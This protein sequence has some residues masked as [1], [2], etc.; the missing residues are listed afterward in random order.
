MAE[1]PPFL[2]LC[3][4][5]RSRLGFILAATLIGVALAGIGAS[6]VAPKYTAKAQVLVDT[7]VARGEGDAAATAS[8]E[9]EEAAMQTEVVE[10]T[11]RDLLRRTVD[12]FA[13]SPPAK[14]VP[15]E[16]AEAAPVAYRPKDALP[17][18]VIAVIDEGR[19][20][21]GRLFG[22]DAVGNV[23]GANESGLTFDELER[24]LFVYQERTS[25]VIAVTFTA[26]SPIKAAAVANRIVELY[27]ADHGARRREEAN[28]TLDWLGMREPELAA[29]L[30]RAK[31]AVADY[32][33]ANAAILAN[34][35]EIF[36][37]LAIDLSHQ[38][39][40]AE[41]DVSTRR[42]RAAY[43]R[44]LKRRGDADAALG[45]LN[46]PLVAELSQQELALL[47]TQAELAASLGENHPKMLQIRSQL[48]EIRQRIGQEL[49]LALTAL[50]RE[51]QLSADQLGA[52]RDRLRIAKEEA[53]RARRAELGLHEL[54]L[55]ADSKRQTFDDVVK[56][57]KELRDQQGLIRA[58]AQILTTAMP[59]IKP[60]SPAP[61]L[62]LVPAAVIFSICSGLWVVIANRL[63]QCLRTPGEI[64]DALSVPCIGL[65]PRL[66]RIA[67]SRPHRQLLERPLEVYAESIR[68][69]A[70]SLRLVGD[71]NP[72]GTLLISSSIPGEGKTTLAA[73]LAVYMSTLERR[74][75]LLD[76]DFRRPAI[77]RE[78]GGDPEKRTFDI[79][80]DDAPASELTQRA[81]GLQ[82]DYLPA[83]RQGADPLMLFVGRRLPQ[84][85]ERLRAGY[86]LIVID[87]PPLLAVTEARLLAMMVDKVVFAI[88]WQSTHRDVAR[89]ALELLRVATAPVG[90]FAERVS[91]VLT[92]VELEK[93]AR[94]RK[95]SR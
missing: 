50:E 83:S 17:D 73:S 36:D 57:L 41:L 47:R 91:V 28:A 24:R 84:L 64:T 52:I 51:A 67:R 88:K 39:A 40:S 66:R 89:N 34:R 72:P 61:L 31:R 19:A 69:I 44:E 60:S 27:L 21:L 32:H 30:A 48:Q 4:V 43:L 6:M 90:D 22:L 13:R 82:L 33:A 45:P 9:G 95:R 12:S 1:T 2:E 20:R 37:Q 10:L 77:L 87:S 8:A 18:M 75:L 85:I 53:A 14:P 92:Q 81:P 56:R 49:D 16:P 80:R 11:S 7:L 68:S 29:E 65:V 78:L 38:L 71:E 59:P 74:V 70:A 76:L 42:A 55:A 94:Y 62:F 79:L 26:T 5:L 63:R 58:G 23:G 3:N 46:S 93:H 86:D 54:E 25:R 15:A 35:P